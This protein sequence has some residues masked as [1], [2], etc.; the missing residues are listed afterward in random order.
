MNMRKIA[1]LAGVSPATVSRVF[2][3]NTGVNEETAKK[4]RKIASEYNYHPQI[5]EKLKNV[6]IITPY[7]NVYPVQS[8]IDM[9]LMALTGVLPD[10]GFRV[11]ILPLNSLERLPD[12][13][14]CAAVAIGID[15]AMLPDWEENY[16][17]PLIF[18]DRSPG[19]RKQANNVFFVNSDEFSGMELAL[20]H[21]K[22]RSCKKI[23]CIIHGKRGE[24]NTLLRESAILDILK[25]LHLPDSPSL[26][27]FS[28]EDSSRY[29]ELVGKL[30]K[31]GIDALFCPGG[32][33]GITVL[34]ALSLYGRQVPEDI[35]LIVSEQTFFSN[36]AVPPQTTIT[37]EYA[38]L[39]GKVLELICARTSGKKFPR[40]TTLPYRLIKRE[41]VK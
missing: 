29:V 40:I 19:G 11:E 25:K 23:G 37:Q 22:E 6:V 17:E 21:L 3:R 5:S 36:Y 10:A 8:C 1:E 34:Y 31:Q 12:I 24:G 28:G 20:T 2:N 4:I 33:A 16:N 39:A 30:L 41:S 27:Q 13:R 32:N 38:L 35:S 14:F 18:L 26:I 15:P 7:N 9:L